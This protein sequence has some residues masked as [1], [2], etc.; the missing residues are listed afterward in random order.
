[1][2]ICLDVFDNSARNA[3]PAGNARAVLAAFVRIRIAMDHERS[4][5]ARKDAER[6]LREGHAGRDRLQAALTALIHRD[7]GQ[8]ACVEWMIDIGVAV[9][10]GTWIA[11]SARQI[12]ALR[13]RHDP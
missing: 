13:N 4:S 1:M 7:V 3:R 8:I 5:F 6:S 10:R 11:V 12:E 2:T 9:A